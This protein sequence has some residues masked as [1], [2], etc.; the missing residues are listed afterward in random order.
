M[1]QMLSSCTYKLYDSEYG[2]SKFENRLPGIFDPKKIK[3]L[4]VESHIPLVSEIC[5]NFCVNF[6]MFYR[7]ASSF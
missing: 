2:K 6:V 4:T 1:L 5:C 3:H 7:N